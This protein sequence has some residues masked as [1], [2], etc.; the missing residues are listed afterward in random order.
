VIPRTLIGIVTATCQ[1]PHIRK[2]PDYRA[3]K[4]VNSPRTH[5]AAGDPVQMDEI[6]VKLLNAAV[7]TVGKPVD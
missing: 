7:N 1:W 5:I 3:I 6:R 4:I 2:S